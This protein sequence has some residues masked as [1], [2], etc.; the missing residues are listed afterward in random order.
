MLEYVVETW[1]AYFGIGLV[2]LLFAK[3]ILLLR[4]L[5]YVMSIGGVVLVGWGCWS[6][7]W[8]HK[9]AYAGSIPVP[10]IG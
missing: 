5:T 6:P 7:H 8:P 3:P 1:T 2:G 10:P 9:P 4:L